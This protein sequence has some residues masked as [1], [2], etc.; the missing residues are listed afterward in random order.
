MSWDVSGIASSTTRTVT[1][2]DVNVNLG[3]IPAIHSANGNSVTGTNAS[4]VAGLTNTASAQ[5]SSVLGGTLNVASGKYSVIL[6]GDSNTASGHDQTILNGRNITGIKTTGAI[7]HGGLVEGTVGDAN[8]TT[9][10]NYTHRGRANINTTT[11]ITSTGSTNNLAGLTVADQEARLIKSTLSVTSNP[12]VV[13][14]CGIHEITFMLQSS[15]GS[16]KTM[17]AGQRRALVYYG[18][19]TRTLDTVQTVG[20]DHTV[21]SIACTF[22]VELYNEYIVFKIVNTD[23]IYIMANMSVKSTYNNYL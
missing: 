1:M 23:S 8:G 11:W 6:N 13:N 2:P 18:G 12:E 14:A 21:G 5:Y 3:A 19:T 17:L 22:T 9:V 7:I 10:V 15:S 16:P 20:T 4:V